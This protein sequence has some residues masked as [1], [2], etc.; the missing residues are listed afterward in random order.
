MENK[1]S[2]FIP[3]GIIPGGVLF[4]K[5]KKHFEKIKNICFRF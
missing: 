4:L 5:I 2:D 3:T 1:Y